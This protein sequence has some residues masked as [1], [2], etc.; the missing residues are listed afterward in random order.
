MS[1]RSK[2]AVLNWGNIL[3][4]TT[5]HRDG[6]YTAYIMDNAGSRPEIGKLEAGNRSMLT[7]VLGWLAK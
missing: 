6:S 5:R 2:S 7:E 1:N 3:A 4:D